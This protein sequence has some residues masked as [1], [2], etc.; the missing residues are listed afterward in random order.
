VVALRAFVVPP[1]PWIAEA[2][3]RLNILKRVI[4]GG[5][6]EIAADL[7][8]ARDRVRIRAG[9]AT[10][11]HQYSGDGGERLEAKRQRGRH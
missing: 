6:L 10:G 7:L 11:E 5:A 8:Y 2:P 9:L 3:T 4:P 1:D